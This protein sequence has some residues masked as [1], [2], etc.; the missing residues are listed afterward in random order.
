[1][2]YPHIQNEKKT[3]KNKTNQ[4][5]KQYFVSNEGGGV[6][7]TNGKQ[8]KFGMKYGNVVFALFFVIA[9]KLDCQ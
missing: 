7:K 8:D 1:M 9:E 3:Q 4:Q 2:I 6:Y 5:I